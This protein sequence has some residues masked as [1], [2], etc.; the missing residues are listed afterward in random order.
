MLR[1]DYIFFL[2]NNHRVENFKL[3][4]VTKNFEK[5]LKRCDGIAISNFF[6]FKRNVILVE[7]FATTHSL[8]EASLSDS[9]VVL[10]MALNVDSVQFNQI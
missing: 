1:H 3:Q 5:K 2:K 9:S 7:I 4:N 8:A 6:T 10:K